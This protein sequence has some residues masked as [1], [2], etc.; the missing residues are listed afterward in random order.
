[1]FPDSSID[2]HDPSRSLNV[3]GKK[4]LWDGCLYESYDD[5]LCKAEIYKK[6]NFEVYLTQEAEKYLVYSRKVVN[7][8]FPTAS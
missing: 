5:A 2:S 1:M 6:D 3:E 7:E 4:F 8:V